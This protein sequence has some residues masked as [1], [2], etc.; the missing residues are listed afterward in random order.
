MKKLLPFIF[1][2][3]TL[4]TGCSAEPLTPKQTQ[5]V[6]EKE[7]AKL[8]E[9]KT[10]VTV[11]SSVLPDQKYSTFKVSCVLQS[12]HRDADQD[13][14]KVILMEQVKRDAVE[15]LF[16]TML[17]SDTLIVDGK[18]V[19]DKVKQVAIG[20]VRI[21]GKPQF[22]NGEN[23]GEVCTKA[24]AYITEDDF[25]K[26]QPQ[27]VTV[28]NFCYNNP[29]ISLKKL[30][31]EAEFSAYRK[32]ITKFSPKMKNIGNE[33]AE[34]YIHGFEKSNEDLDIQTSVFCMDFSAK[35]FP[36]ELELGDIERIVSASSTASNSLNALDVTFYEN[37]DYA[38][39]KPIYTTA[40]TQD[41]DLFGKSFI[42]NKLQKDS[43]YYIRIS[44]F[45]YSNIDR[46]VNYQLKSDVYS[47]QVKI[48]NKKVV[49]KR[50]TRGGITLKS[51]YNPIEIL[52][53]SSNTYDVKLLEKQSDGKFTP[54]SI[55]KLYIKE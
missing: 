55:S 50:D 23:W 16:G 25:Q 45:I 10:S 20:S 36:Y 22:Y 40:I 17:K 52:V 37:T 6:A 3:T 13:Q 7:I 5:T 1:V 51:G 29:D 34:S 44:G 24:E 30:K 42:N 26:Y 48:N 27:T 31:S 39:K 54:L 9:V 41:L 19:S 32:A 33:Q 4:F 35:L 18:L 47:V 28:K 8:D 11:S 14:L 15:E 43:A 38:F 2:L 53:T 49:A 46:Y 12:E 21:K